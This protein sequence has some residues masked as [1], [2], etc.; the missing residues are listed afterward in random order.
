MVDKDQ[1]N[2]CNATNFVD[3]FTVRDPGTGTATELQ[4]RSMEEHKIESDSVRPFVLERRWTVEQLKNEQRADPDLAPIITALEDGER[5]K[6][7]EVS[8]WPASAR[9][10]L[11][12]WDSLKW[13]DGPLR[14][15]WYDK[16]GRVE[17]YQTIVP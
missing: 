11:A 3:S 1:L 10:Y 13:D 14:R 15:E 8:D 12:S 6:D 17:K 9:K 2:M 16:S 5:P 7:D 4:A